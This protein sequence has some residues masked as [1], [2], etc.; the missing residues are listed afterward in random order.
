MP[1][2]TQQ[3]LGPP[4]AQSVSFSRPPSPSSSP[5]RP[6]RSYHPRWGYAPR[7]PKGTAYSPT[8]GGKSAGGAQA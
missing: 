8:W 4:T 3:H 1:R 5:S 7:I 6:P 2:N